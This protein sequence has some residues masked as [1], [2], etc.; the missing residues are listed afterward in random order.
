[1]AVKTKQKECT[2]HTIRLDSLT[3]AVE[4]RI[5]D[6]L[7]EFIKEETWKKNKEMILKGQNKYE[8]EIEFKEKL[9]QETKAEKEF[10]SEKIVMAYNDRA[11]GVLSENTFIDIRKSAEEQI[12]LCEKKTEELDREIESLKNKCSERKSEIK[13][14]ES[15]VDNM[16]L[17]REIIE[18]CI[19]YIE[20]G[21]KEQGQQKIN[22]YWSF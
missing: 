18:E 9:I 13:N 7:K 21:E 3:I 5:K 22:V 14:I 20:I 6:I 12:D 11:K 8:K 4:K 17:D 16:N 1:M 15:Y 10:I 19:D 2:Y